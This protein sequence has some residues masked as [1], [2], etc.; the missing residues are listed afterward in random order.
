MKTEY[1]P[2]TCVECKQTTTYVLAVD[3]GT[4]E[5]VKAIAR[6]IETKGINIVHPRKEMEGQYLTSN[7]VGNLS[8]ARMQ[9]LIAAV[10]G[11]PGNY[12]LTRKGSAF[13]N[14]VPVHKY[15]IRSK[16]E[17]RSIGY[18]G[19]EMCTIGDFTSDDE[20]WE[21]VNYEIVEGRV[22]YKV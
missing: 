4:A 10:D 22:V 14:G 16:A 9:G 15:V 7:Q 1:V 19:D 20:R 17:D 8:R 3:R 6:F 5:I 12:C 13:L 2:D 11:N 21:G 18:W